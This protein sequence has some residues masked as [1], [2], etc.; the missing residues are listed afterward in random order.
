LAILSKECNTGGFTIPSFKLHY[1]AIAIKTV[2]YWHKNRY[3]NQW[4]EIKDLNVY[5]YSNI[6]LISNKGAKNI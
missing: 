3:E 5:P 6:Q 4:K 1:R 2:W